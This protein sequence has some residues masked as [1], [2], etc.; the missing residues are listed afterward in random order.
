MFQVRSLSTMGKSKVLRRES[1]GFWLLRVYLPESRPPARG[2]QASRPIFWSSRSGTFEVAAGDGVVGLQGVDGCE[3]LELGY[4][5]GFH[6]APGVP[7]GDADVADLA[8]LDE[9]VEGTEGLFKGSNEVGAVDLVEVDVV[10]VEALEG[11]FDGV[12]DVAAG[13]AYVVAAGSGAAEGLGGNDDVFTGDVEVLE[14]LAEH[15]LGLAVGVDVGGVDEVDAGVDGGLDEVIDLLLVR[16][17][18][19]FPDPFRV[20]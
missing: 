2:L 18:D 10:G 3:V 15:G 11:G 4:A 13:C 17:G 8:M 5:C 1:A 14:R 16:A 12:H 20:T 6:D 19:V 9:G 7:V